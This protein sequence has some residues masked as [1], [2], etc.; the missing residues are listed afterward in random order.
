MARSCRISS[1]SEDNIEDD[2]I[3]KLFA[4]EDEFDA[5]FSG[6]S[7]NVSHVDELPG[8]AK[9]EAASQQVLQRGEGESA[10]SLH[11]PNKLKQ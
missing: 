3:M 4:S 1:D 11:S 6:F 2:Q 5:S 10:P 7:E 9:P 8:L